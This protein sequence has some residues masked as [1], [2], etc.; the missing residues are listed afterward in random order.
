MLYFVAFV[1][2]SVKLFHGL[3]K[4]YCNSQ[5]VAVS[6]LGKLDLDVRSPE[7]QGRNTRSDFLSYFIDMA[8]P[9]VIDGHS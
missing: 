4:Q 5:I 2:Y 7:G 1:P 6:K 9:I 8:T 3:P